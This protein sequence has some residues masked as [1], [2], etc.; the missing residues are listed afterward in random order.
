MAI[1]ADSPE[2]ILLFDP[3]EPGRRTRS[4]PGVGLWVPTV[5]PDGRS[6]VIGTH[7]G[8]ACTVRDAWT[9]RRVQNL[10]ARI[11]RPAFSPDNRWLVIGSFEKY[12]FHEFDGELWRCVR[13]LPRE[14]GAPS[15]GLVAFTGDARMVALTDSVRS[16]RLLETE[17]WR[18]L[19][20]ISAPDSEEI[21]SLCFSPDCSQLAAGTNDG[22]VQ[23]WDLRRIRARLRE[24]GLDWDPPAQVSRSDEDDRPARVELEL[25]AW[26]EPERE[27][28]I[29]AICPFD[30][31]A[32]YR[33]GLA[34]ALRDQL[35]EA[36]DDFRRALAL[37]PN[38]A[39][40]LYRR[41]LVLIR[42]GK[43]EEAITA[44]SRAITLEP[45]HAGAHVARGHA[46]DRLGRRDEAVGVYA[47]LIDLRPDWPE[48]PNKAAWMLATHPEPRRRDIGRAIIWARKAVE[49]DPENEDYWNTLGVVLYRAGDWRGAIQALERSVSIQGHNSYDDF[50]L[51][52]SRWQLGER[53]DALRLYDDAVRWMQ[54]KQPNDEELRRFRAEASDMLGIVDPS[55]SKR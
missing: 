21:N 44:L 33:R 47:R 26:T 11:A 50:F 43:D 41:G 55:Q 39:G 23:L 8:Y 22:V 36:L 45:D 52:M 30:A 27:S 17:R 46:L 53:Q 29:L 28:L 24:M 54:Q 32:Y 38:H 42:Q 31:D 16:I 48:F 1:R 14:K 40:A 10:P 9:G 49:L 34:Y 13:S 25:G 3:E 18:E 4:L 51:A 12:D 20:T 15:P 6:V 37:K 5:S 7:N 2:R 35:R 19:A